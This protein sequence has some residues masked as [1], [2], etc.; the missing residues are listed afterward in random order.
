VSP[1]KGT[2]FPWTPEQVA[3]L[4][5]MVAEGRSY[6]E[7]GKAL[8]CSR[9]A[10][11]GKANR[12]GIDRPNRVKASPPMRAPKVRPMPR[13][14]VGNLPRATKVAASMRAILGTGHS[15]TI[16]PPT[17]Y[18]ER[19]EPAGKVTLMELGAHHCKWPIGDPASDTFRFCG[20]PRE[21]E[22]SYCSR[23]CEVAYVK[24]RPRPPST[25]PSAHRR[26]A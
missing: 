10:C 3:T 17:P 12:L 20:E 13:N 2:A 1:P 26:V 19:I 23:H 6:G 21:G 22:R 7:I 16:K 9:C 15:P 11:I 4:T 8:G 5:K 25:A 14:P 24:P 18:V